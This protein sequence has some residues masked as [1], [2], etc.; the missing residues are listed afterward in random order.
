MIMNSHLY[1]VNIHLIFFLSK[2][3]KNHETLSQKIKKG[4]SNKLRNLY[5]KLKKKLPIIT[6]EV[7]LY[8]IEKIVFILLA[9]I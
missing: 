6:F 4:P 5:M 3:V 9:F 7:I 8:K 2:S 1:I